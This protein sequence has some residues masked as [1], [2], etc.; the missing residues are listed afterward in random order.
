MKQITL[1]FTALNEGREV[2]NTLKSLYETANPDLFDVIVIN[3]GT[4]KSDYSIG[5]VNIPKKYKHTLINH[6]FRQGIHA[7][8]SEGASLAQTK[9]IAFFNS[10][11]RFEAGWLDKV[12]WELDSDNGKTIFC[13]TSKVLN[14]KGEHIKEPNNGYLYGAEILLHEDAPKDHIHNHRILYPK[15]IYEKKQ[16]TYEIPCVLGA[17]YF[18]TKKW[19]NYIG[20]LEGLSSYGSDEEFLSL[21]T[22]CFGGKCKIISDIAIGN[23]YRKVKT[24]VDNLE[25]FLFNRIY[26][27]L[28]LLDEKDYK[29]IVNWYSDNQYFSLMMLRI[30][31]NFNYI[32]GIK[33]KYSRMIV[34]NVNNYLKK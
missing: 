1:I 18:M 25:D 23:I 4:F 29:K 7:S 33:A 14:E 3:D 10:R 9:Y 6:E 11:M 8:R 34:N 30:A 26:M 28:V 2:V 20:G 27:A 12:L 16:G 24:Y 31:M 21:K 19:F 13:T 22:W 17:M 32:S 5:W 15:W